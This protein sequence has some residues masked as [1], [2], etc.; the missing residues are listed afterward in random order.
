V[1][2]E[3]HDSTNSKN[4]QKAPWES[5]INEP[6]FVPLNP[7]NAEL[8]PICHL[9]ALLGGHLIFHVSRIRVNAYSITSMCIVRSAW[10]GTMCW[11][12]SEP[13][14]PTCSW[15]VGKIR[16]N[17][18][19]LYFESVATNYWMKQNK[20][21]QKK[22]SQPSARWC[23]NNFARIIRCNV[24]SHCTGQCRCWTPASHAA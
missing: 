15:A 2:R 17:V 7:L 24:P 16:I 6:L 23:G 18:T 20:T 5:Q 22:P 12:E 13:Y 21:E 8:N 4:A 11:A 14:E 9:L 3:N 10:R 1:R 19:A